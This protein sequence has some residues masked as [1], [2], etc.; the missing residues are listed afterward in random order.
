MHSQGEFFTQSIWIRR[1]VGF[2]LDMTG[3]EIEDGNPEEGQQEQDQGNRWMA[4]RPA[5][6]V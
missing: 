1:P 3:D 4:V 2:D 5:Q 6:I